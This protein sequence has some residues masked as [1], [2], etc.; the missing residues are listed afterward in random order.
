MSLNTLVLSCPVDHPAVH[1]LL[2]D[3]RVTD[4]TQ[5]TLKGDF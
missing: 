1:R 2:K 3:P 4:F 5:F